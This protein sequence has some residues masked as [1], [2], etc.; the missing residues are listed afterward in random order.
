MDVRHHGADVSP[1]VG[2]AL[3]L[4]LDVLP[5]GGVPSLLVALV[6]GVDL[7]SGLAP[8]VRVSEDELPDGGVEHEAVDPVAGGEDDH[9]G[10]AV[11]SVPGSHN[12]SPGLESIAGSQR[13]LVRLLE[14]RKDGP[15]RD[16]TVD[17]GAAVQGVEGDDVFSLAFSLHLYLIVVLLQSHSQPL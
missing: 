8:H 14:D 5:D 16:E 1:T 7:P 6:D 4:G 11:Q 2:L 3:L 15:D 9:G 12:L 13:T 10:A 17:V